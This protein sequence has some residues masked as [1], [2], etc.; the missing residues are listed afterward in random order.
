MYS[1]RQDELDALNS[2]RARSARKL[3][4]NGAVHADLCPKIMLHSM[5]WAIPCR[6]KTVKPTFGPDGTLDLQA[7]DPFDWPEINAYIEAAKISRE[8]VCSECGQPTKATLEADGECLKAYFA[9]LRRALSVQYN[10]SD[11]E[12]ASLAQFS[13]DELPVA[14]EQLLRWAQGQDVSAPLWEADDGANA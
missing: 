11:D 8:S 14:C 10:L 1:R 12:F 5:P 3:G 9:L 4:E 2:L 6:Q 7:D 13:S